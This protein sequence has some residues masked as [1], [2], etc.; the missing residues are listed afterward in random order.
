M[1]VRRI[2]EV[3]ADSLSSL[4]TT[5]HRLLLPP[6]LH[7]FHPRT[8]STPE[9]STPPRAC[10]HAR[11]IQV[12]RSQAMSVTAEGDPHRRKY[13]HPSRS[14]SLSSLP[15]SCNQ[16]ARALEIQ[17]LPPSASWCVAL[18]ASVGSKG[19]TASVFLICHAQ[20]FEYHCPHPAF[21]FIFTSWNSGGS[22]CRG[23]TYPGGAR[24][25]GCS[26]GEYQI[27]T[28]RN[29]STLGRIPSKRTILSRYSE[30]GIFFSVIL[31]SYVAASG[32]RSPNR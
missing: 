22:W 4:S 3:G 19:F 24:C 20:A 8:I 16:D 29:A 27:V 31:L 26:Y 21:A 11:R 32:L 17:L 30:T 18:C 28:A 13:F 7:C 9:H 25:N 15:N 2:S 23:N 5:L 1:F 6:P 12:S 14:S 10:P